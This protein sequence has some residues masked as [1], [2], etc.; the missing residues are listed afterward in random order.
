MVM[1]PHNDDY[2]PLMGVSEDASVAAKG[3]TLDAIHLSHGEVQH[4]YQ[5]TTEDTKDDL[6]EAL[7]DNFSVDVDG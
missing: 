2:A 3:W 5:L 6:A 1:E 7:A 4:W